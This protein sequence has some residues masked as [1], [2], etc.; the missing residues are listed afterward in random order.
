M[1]R[2]YSPHAVKEILSALPPI[3]KLFIMFLIVNAFLIAS[4]VSPQLVVFRNTAIVKS[5]NVGVYWDVNCSSPVEGIDWGIIEPSENKTVLVYLRNEG[6]SEF[7]F[8]IW[9]ANWSSPEAESCI[10]L[11]SDYPGQLVVVGDIVSVALILSV[12]PE[13]LDITSFSFDV[14]IEVSG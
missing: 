3:F 14:V 13:I 4:T 6:N 2:G 9:A 12:A 1:P 10:N 5:I 7:A 8:L 11:N